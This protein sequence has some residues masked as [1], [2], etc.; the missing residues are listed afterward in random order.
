VEAFAAG[1]LGGHADSGIID[2]P[3]LMLPVATTIAAGHGGLTEFPP[4]GIQDPFDTFD[5]LSRV[6]REFAWSS[7]SRATSAGCVSHDSQADA[8]CLMIL[9]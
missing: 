1:S 5:T 3:R 9:F 4:I 6:F 2:T 8:V 7:V